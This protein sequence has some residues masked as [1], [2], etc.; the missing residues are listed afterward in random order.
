MVSETADFAFSAATSRTRPNNVV[1]YS[2]LVAP[3]C[4]N[5]M[6]L[7]TKPD[8]HCSQRVWSHDYR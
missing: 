5:M 4:A 7:S 1:F 3:L 2:A 8:V 6:T